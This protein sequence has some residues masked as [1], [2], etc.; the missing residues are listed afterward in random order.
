MYYSFVPHFRQAGVSTCL[1]GAEQEN[2]QQ[3]EQYDQSIHALHIH[4]LCAGP[5][6]LY[7][8]SSTE[9]PR[10]GCSPNSMSCRRSCCPIFYSCLRNTPRRWCGEC[11]KCRR[12]AYFCDILQ[13]PR[14]SIGMPSDVPATL[15]DMPV[16][17]FTRQN[18]EAFV[19]RRKSRRLQETS[20]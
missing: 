1:F 12:L 19:E 2:A 3:P 20:G 16:E 14:E 5:S 9:H 4:G 7:C 17:Q 10:C 11:G 18:A 8:R 13:I 6:L 15:S